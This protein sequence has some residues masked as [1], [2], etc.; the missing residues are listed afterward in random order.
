M[1]SPLGDAS[2]SLYP[3]HAAMS[4]YLEATD[5]SVSNNIDRS[6]LRGRQAQG[7]IRRHELKQRQHSEIQTEL[8]SGRKSQGGLDAKT[9]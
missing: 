3:R 2:R 5:W 8:I 9:Y 7:D 1:T 6:F 4:S